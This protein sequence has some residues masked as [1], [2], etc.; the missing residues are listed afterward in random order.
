MYY[1]TLNKKEKIWITEEY[2]IGL[3]KKL[4]NDS[5]IGVKQLNLTVTPKYY[6]KNMHKHIKILCRTCETCIK[7]KSR[8]GR[9]KQPLSQL[10]P[11]EKPF[12]I[13]SLATVGGFAG[14][15]S[16]K[17]FL[18]LIID[19]FTKN[20][21]ALTIRKIIITTQSAKDFKNLVKKI[22]KKK[23]NRNYFYWTNREV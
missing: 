5:H 17:K 14:N 20:A 6:F 22:Q 3:I 21:F 15:R 23:Y 10:G 7:N 9:F 4:H 18:H 1:K 16:Q 2:G 11:A 8:F 19:H 13:V 12:Q